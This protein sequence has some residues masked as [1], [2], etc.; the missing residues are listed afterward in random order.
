MR[1]HI[2]AESMR[3]VTEVCY[4][5]GVVFGLPD[6]L[7]DHLMEN[8]RNFYCPNGHAQ[9]YLAK[10]DKERLEEERRRH[11]STQEELRIARLEAATAERKA[12][13]KVKSL[14]K[15]ALATQCLHCPRTID[16]ARMRRHVETKHPGVLPERVLP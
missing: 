4:E 2:I 3:L 5:C 7:Q 13:A 14:E 8:H 12:R 10:S 6:Q 16:P 1:G 11:A 15:K 9:H